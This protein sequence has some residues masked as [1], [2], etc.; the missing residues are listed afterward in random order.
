MTRTILTIVVYAGLL[1]CSVKESETANS[2]VEKVETSTPVTL[3]TDKHPDKNFSLIED[4][5]KSKGMFRPDT[6][7]LFD[8]STDGGQLIAYHTKDKDYLVLD[9][10]LFGETGK[11]HSTYWTDRKLNFKIVKRT[12]F[13]Y[14]RPYYEKD[15]K[16]TETTEFYSYS[17]N[18][19]IRY[20]SNKQEI[21][22]PDNV[23]SEKKI[24][25]FFVDITKEIEIIK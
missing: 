25:D 17:G 10:W 14:D 6:F 22:N 2:T 15:Y 9:I 13:A 23:E 12:D 7:E 24:K 11:T 18:S 16:I 8:H 19:F 5:E 20:N 1:S 4:F 3:T 21:K